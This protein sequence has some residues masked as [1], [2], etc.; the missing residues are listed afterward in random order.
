MILLRQYTCTYFWVCRC[1]FL[2]PPPLHRRWFYGRLV[3]SQKCWG[4]FGPLIVSC[5]LQRGRDPAGEFGRYPPLFWWLSLF[6]CS[7]NRVAPDCWLPGNF[8]PSFP[9]PS[10]S[11][12]LNI[13][14]P[15]V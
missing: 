15:I 14:P 6:S 5:F 4:G 7:L 2:P 12:R 10:F 9:M 11:V 3:H 8:P 1:W 13:Y